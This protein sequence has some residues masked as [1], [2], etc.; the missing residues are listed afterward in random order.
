[1]LSSAF[2]II[3]L[4]LLNQVTSNNQDIPLIILCGGKGTRISAMY[5]HT[6]KG[7]ININQSNIILNLLHYY[8]GQN[9]IYLALGH[10]SESYIEFF[11]NKNINSELIFEVE[12]NALGTGGAINNIIK[13]Y[14]LNRFYVMNGD[15]DYKENLAYLDRLSQLHDASVISACGSTEDNQFGSILYNKQT[16][17]LLSFKEKDIN[18]TGLVYSG[19]SLLKKE[20][21]SNFDIDTQ[22]S[23][24]EDI[25]SNNA[26]EIYVHISDKKFYDIGTPDRLKKA[27][28]LLK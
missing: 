22:F 25:F 10:L 24:E 21:F 13:K 19:L 27:R 5:P 8:E 15:T 26:H 17:K 4:R 23:L 6:P 18:K 2:Q 12:K 11:K 20:L 14:N 16:N 3:H 9:I 1:M 7:L 28:K